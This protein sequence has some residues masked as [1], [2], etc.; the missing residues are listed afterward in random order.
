LTSEEDNIIDDLAESFKKVG[1]MHVILKTKFGIVSGETRKKASEKYGLKWPEKEIEIKD[2]YDFLQKKAADNIH[3][4]KDDQWWKQVVDKAAEVLINNNF[5]VGEIAEK[6]LH[7][8]PISK[9][10]L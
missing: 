7:D 3:K 8:F 6:L 10:R 1:P 2:E 9:N 4:E 5:K